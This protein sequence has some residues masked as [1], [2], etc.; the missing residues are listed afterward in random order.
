MI[1]VVV[2]T[3][4]TDCGGLGGSETF[5]RRRR[6]TT[7]RSKEWLT[8]TSLTNEM[9][10]I[11][12]SRCVAQRRQYCSCVP[13]ARMVLSGVETL[14][15]WSL[16]AENLGCRSRAMR[17]PV[18]ARDGKTCG[19]SSHVACRAVGADGQTGPEMVPRLLV[20]VGFRG[21]AKGKRHGNSPMSRRTTRE[22]SQRG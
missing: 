8:R 10:E 13:L 3:R 12:P 14:G 18:P 21:V 11:V 20:A 22:A 5:S 19:G 6:L 17:P 16:V 2:I 15:W 9:L 7:G 1:R 4:T